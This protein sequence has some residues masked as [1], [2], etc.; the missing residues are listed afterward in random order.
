ML[1]LTVPSAPR[2]KAI[3]KK[4]GYSYDSGKVCEDGDGEDAS[5]PAANTTVT[6]PTTPVKAKVTPTA[7]T[8]PR[9]KKRKVND[10]VDDGG[11]LVV[12]KREASTEAQDS[13]NGDTA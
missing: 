8:G 4:L 2:F 10:V 9:G 5:S 6:A 7:S 13:S 1:L 11:S 12:V 3:L